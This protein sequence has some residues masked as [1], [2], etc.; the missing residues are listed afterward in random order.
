MYLKMLA[1]QLKLKK[2]NNV[3]IE[4]GKCRGANFAIITSYSCI[5]EVV[6]EKATSICA[7]T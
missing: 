2:K 7:C 5:S 1:R 4:L 6:G 3:D